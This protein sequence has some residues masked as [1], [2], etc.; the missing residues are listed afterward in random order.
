MRFLLLRASVSCSKW[1]GSCRL[2]EQILFVSAGM[3]APKKRDHLLARQQLYLNYGALTL[4]TLLKRNG[5][6]PVLIHGS[7]S[8]PE[9][10]VD[11]LREQRRLPTS[12][13][14]MLSI[15]SFFALEWAQKFCR[16]LKKLFPDTK[17]VAG[18]RWVVGP[19]P[20]WLKQKIPEIDLT[21]TGLAEKL[22][23]DVIDPA[24]WSSLDYRDGAAVDLSGQ[25]ELPPYP[26]DH[27]LVDNFRLFQPSI[28]ISRGCGMG[29]VFCEERAIPLSKLRSPAMVAQHL[30][31]V[32]NQYGSKDIRPYFQASLF[33]PNPRWA[34]QLS[35][36][37]QEHNCAVSW[38][39][40]TRVDCM[41]S[42]TIELLARSGLKVVD[43]GMET[44]SPQ[45]MLLMKK[46]KDPDKYL[47]RA[48][49]AIRD[50]AA[51]G[52][53]VKINILLYAGETKAT[54]AETTSWLRENKA[55][56]KGVSVGP[57]LAFGSPKPASP[58]IAELE[59]LGARAVDPES[60]ATTGITE[61]HLSNEIDAKSAEEI[62][63]SLSR[64]MMDQRDY[65]D[66]KSFSYYPRDYTYENFIRDAQKSNPASLPFKSTMHEIRHS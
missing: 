38:R 42:E 61:L 41:T 40:E 9:Q 35:H 43:L 47:Q 18:G 46:T 8:K 22:I 2:D 34:R 6:V 3:L 15:P 65:Y 52:I 30:S 50:F 39:C 20:N 7:H 25:G 24:L 37:I 13:P 51:N 63:L 62:S 4:T 60:A 17:I 66:L 16:Y 44:A 12:H 1:K 31:E 29:C 14:V 53:L 55:Y 10:F 11:S 26:L 48:S 5:Y 21:S 58:L 36:E 32:I 33:L 54:V 64:M 56:I 28:D 57:V 45:Q 23:C 27:A 19:D 59:S 49:V